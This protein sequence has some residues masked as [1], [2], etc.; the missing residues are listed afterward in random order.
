MNEGKTARKGCSPGSIGPSFRIHSE[1]LRL[2]VWVTWGDRTRVDGQRVWMRDPR[3]ATL[4]I[5]IPGDDGTDDI[6]IPASDGLEIH[7]VTRS[8]SGDDGARDRTVSTVLLNRR[9]PANSDFP[10]LR[11]RTYEF[12]PQMKARSE[13]PFPHMPVILAFEGSDWDETIAR[14]RYAGSPEHATCHGVSAEWDVTEGRCHSVRT[15]WIGRGAVHHTRT[16]EHEHL[17]SSM[18][19]LGRTADGAAAEAML[20]PLLAGYLEWSDEQ[21]DSWRPSRERAE[22]AAQLLA[23]CSARRRPH[24]PR[25]SVSPRLCAGRWAG[26]AVPRSPPRAFLC[27]KPVGLSRRDV[28]FSAHGSLQVVRERRSNSVSMD[29][30]QPRWESLANHSVAIGISHVAVSRM[31]S[32][33]GRDAVLA[34]FVASDPPVAVV[35][36]ELQWIT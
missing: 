20:T 6:D 4:S 32:R 2:D 16:T 24:G 28:A 12:Q 13:L 18:R 30:S 34:R 23:L 11:D 36:V 14:L 17:E 31:A 25:N 8:V 9:T 19:E 7:Y 33:N 27:F 29:P 22:S 21:S 35:V 15:V 1:T 10:E 5:P 3:E 26:E